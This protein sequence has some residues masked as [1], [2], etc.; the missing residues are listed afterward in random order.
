VTNQKDSIKDVMAGIGGALLIA[1]AMCTPFVFRSLRTKWGTLK[2]ELSDKYPGDELVPR[3][4]WSF[5]HAVTIKTPGENVWPWIAQ[6]GQG[7]GG[8]YSYQWLENLAG[9][10]IYNV[11]EIVLRFQNLKIGDEI[12][13]H[14]KTP[15]LVV[16]LMEPG[17]YFVLQGREDQESHEYFDTSDSMPEKYLNVSWGFYLNEISPGK[18]RLLSRY[19]SDYS[20]QFA[21][22]LSLGPLFVEPV[23]FVM[24]RKM[25]RQ[26]KKNAEAGYSVE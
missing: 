10:E 14:V 4:K 18:T 20:D 17:K 1:G 16:S 9:C 11:Y 23:S 19:R 2:K 6:I 8:F 5:T 21:N 12:K 25:L 13:L 15:G 7:R 24:D 3:P 26:I 22:R